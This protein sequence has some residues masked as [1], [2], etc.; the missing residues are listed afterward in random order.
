MNRFGTIFLLMPATL[1]FSSVVH[2]GIFDDPEN[3]EVLPDDISAQELRTTMRGFAFALGA[4]CETCHVAEDPSDMESF[5]FA[6]DDKEEKQKARVML[7]MVASINNDLLVPLDEFDADR[8]TVQCVTCHRG[9]RKP[10]LTSQALDEAYEEN[11]LDAALETYESLRAEYYGSHTYDFSEFVLTEYAGNLARRGEADGAI[12]FLEKNAEYYPD[13]MM[14]Y[15]S[16]GEVYN[17]S[18]N[19]AKARDAYEKALEINPQAG[20]VKQRLSSLDE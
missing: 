18:G 19:K 11:G 9:Q 6:A 16:M 3:L 2:A 8:M 20:F 15:F 17:M 5:D 1:L 10:K 14:T 7:Q 12:A 4:R 13:S